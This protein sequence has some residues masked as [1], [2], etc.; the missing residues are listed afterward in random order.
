MKPE[1]EKKLVN[2]FPELYS[3]YT[4]PVSESLMCFGFSCDDGWYTII[5]ALSKCI[6]HYVDSQIDH[7]IQVRTMQV[8]EKFG[9]LRFYI[10]GGDDHVYGMIEMAEMLSR[11]ICEKCGKLGELYKRGTWLKTLCPKCAKPIA[12]TRCKD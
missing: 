7:E 4:R 1:L 9:G 12:Y 10:N 11:L 2:D 5:Y 6:K 8:K 3:G